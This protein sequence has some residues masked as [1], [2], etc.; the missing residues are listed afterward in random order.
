MFNLKTK[1]IKSTVLFFLLCSFSIA[2]MSAFAADDGISYIYEGQNYVVTLDNS[3]VIRVEPIPVTAAAAVCTAESPCLYD[4]LP[5]GLESYVTSG[6]S[7]PVTGFTY[8]FS[9][10]SPD[11]SFSA[12]RGIIGQAFGLWSNVTRVKPAEVTDGGSGSCAG[13]IRIWWASGDHGDGYPFDGAGGVLAHAF[14]PPPV[15]TS[16]VA[17]D[18]HFDEAETW[19]SPTFG[20]TGIDLMT[21]GAHEIGHALGLGH[22][23]DPYSLMYAYYSSRRA[24]LSYDDIA[25]IRAIYGSR[26]EDVIFQIE[27]ISAPCPGCGS[28]RLAENSIK[29]ELRKKGTTSTY[30]TRYVPKATTDAGGTL[31]DV[32]G[33]SSRNP[34]GSQF[35]AYWWHVGDLYRAQFTL[36][37]TYKDVD[38][39]KVTLAITNNT[40]TGSETLRVSMNGIVLGDIVVSPGESSK[41]GTFSV[42]FVNPACNTRDVGSNLYN[43]G[44]H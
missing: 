12:E 21:V 11:I 43:N 40:L 27:T 26:I 17:G 5:I 36:P 35:D 14:Y 6:G 42:N 9:T 22:S 38:Q 37:S 34:F 32:D 3:S 16:C 10:L 39:V 29:V 2:V 20:G 28:F 19:V 18:I 24:Y 30:H 15:N 25:G 7:W 8:S 41:V 1:N 23:E 4:D 44:K 33:V 13:N 31:A